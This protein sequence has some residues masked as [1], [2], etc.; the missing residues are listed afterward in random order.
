MY[1]RQQLTLEKLRVVMDDLDKAMLTVDQAG[2]IVQANQRARQY[3][4][5][6][7]DWE[8]GHPQTLG[9][10]QK[11]READQTGMAP[12]KVTLLIGQ[13]EKEF[14]FAIKPIQLEGTTVEWVITLDDVRE[15][16]EI[17]RQV[18]GLG[19][20]DAFSI[21]AGNSPAITQAKAVA[22]RVADSD[23]TVLLQGESGTG[24][25]LFA[26]AIHRASQRHH[27]PFVSINCAAIPEHLLE[28]E[29]FGYEDGAFTGARRGGKMG[30]FEAAGKG[31]LFLDEIGDM[32]LHLQGKLLRVLQ[33]REVVRVGGSGKAIPVEARVIA[34]T[35]RDLN[36]LVAAG[37]FRMDLYYR[38]H[39]I[40]ITL[41]PLR[42]R[43]EDILPLANVCLREVS[44]RLH[45][46]IRG[47]SRE[48]QERLFRHDW[49][50]NVRELANAVEYAVHME[51]MAY[52]QA[53][54]LPIASHETGERMPV[55]TS[56]AQLPLGVLHLK[57]L[58]RTAIQQ[59]LQRVRQAKGKKEE[60]AHLLGISRATLFRKIKEHDL[61]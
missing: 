3:L 36:Q 61:S 33:E 27:Q 16:M 14:L 29:L 4:K 12:K 44:A 17:A 35:H 15:V 19:R 58:E 8:Q 38:L 21:I 13:E 59:A 1:A 51:S 48:A 24:K 60:A 55:P 10:I 53:E 52:V 40:P 47:F 45:K 56:P 43:R 26:K 34:A 30:L 32:P 37:L 2:R 25:D 22:R 57:E 54:N 5:L 39:V 20:E 18:G 11:I 6:D 7:G 46:D 28:S 23:S 9:W 49:P 42:D 31:T 41:P 50:G